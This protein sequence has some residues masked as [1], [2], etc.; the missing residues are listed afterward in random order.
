MA[1]DRYL[2]L[3][4]E[5]TYATP[6]AATRYI[7]K[8]AGSLPP[9]QGFIVTETEDEREP[10]Q[11][12]VGH[13][14][15]K[16]GWNQYVGSENTGEQL[17]AAFGAVGTTQ[18]DPVDSPN[19]YLHQFDIA[20]IM[21]SYTIRLGK[22]LAEFVYPGG[23]CKSLEFA[24][25]AKAAMEMTTDWWAQKDLIDTLAVAPV[26]PPK[27]WFSFVQNALKTAGSPENNVRAFTLRL[28][29]DWDEDNFV[30]GSRFIN[31][32]IV[33]GVKC[34]GTADIQFASLDYIERFMGKTGVTEPI[35]DPCDFEFESLNLKTVGCYANPLDT[36]PLNAYL[37]FD[38]PKVIWDKSEARVDRRNHII[39]N[40][41]FQAIKD[42]TADY[43]VQAKLLNSIA[44]Y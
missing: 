33:Q 8:I 7:R 44:S 36:T 30:L 4:K 24:C 14:I 19:A 1:A 40:L 41:G 31:R 11:A 6:V 15:N 5:V 27:D 28:E 21:Q 17:L 34:S 2:G 22:D 29:N 26:F 23:C 37:E 3:G 13:Y 16:G 35:T 10:T 9:E 39:Q 20:K 18:P 42:D 38:L 43:M 25:A 32:N 12:I